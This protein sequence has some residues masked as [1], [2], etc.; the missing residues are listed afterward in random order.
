MRK[1]CPMEITVSSTARTAAIPPHSDVA[2]VRLR[3]LAIARKTTNALTNAGLTVVGDLRQLTPA[4]VSRIPN[5]GVKSINE[6][7]RALRP[8]GVTLADSPARPP[9]THERCAHSRF[10]PSFTLRQLDVPA[11]V[12]RRLEAAA[13]SCLCLVENLT[14]PEL[15]RAMD[16]DTVLTG[17]LA[18][19]IERHRAGLRSPDEHSSGKSHEPPTGL[20]GVEAELWSLTAP[21]VDPRMRRIALEVYGW[22]GGERQSLA[23]IAERHGV[24]VATISS[25]CARVEARWK[26]ES[27][28]MPKLVEM[29]TAIVSQAPALAAEIESDLIRRRFMQRRIPVEGLL[30]AAAIAGVDAP[31]TLVGRE[32]RLILPRGRESAF[33]SVV[34][35]IRRAARNGTTLSHEEVAI[36]ASQ[37]GVSGVSPEFADR[38]RRV[39]SS[40]GETTPGVLS[41][42]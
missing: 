37:N 22:D 23:G 15:L 5:V 28:R 32:S 2:R 26:T 27:A 19:E 29:I 36:V 41:N 11:A 13:I 4:E 14:Q 33:N 3:D 38:V 39:M 25:L 8:L 6:I 35:V 9:V 1:A 20:T 10:D 12:L 16:F 17:A 40:L 7:E 30:A 34:Q 42:V 31:L 21:L 18:A 24:D